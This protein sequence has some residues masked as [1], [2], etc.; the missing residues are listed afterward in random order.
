MRPPPRS[1]LFPYTTLFRSHVAALQNP[2]R[3]RRLQPAVHDHAQRLARRLDI[4]HR[5]PG[6]VGGDR[7]DPRQYGAG[8]SPPAMP[9][10]PR[11]RSRDPLGF[12]VGKRGAAIERGRH[13]E[14]HP[15]P[16]ARHAR[17]EADVQLAG[18]VLEQT[19]LERDA[20]ANE[21]FAA[22]RGDRIRVTHRR[23]D[24]PDFRLD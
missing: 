9:V 7:A 15:R 10:A 3:A 18:L 6:V 13:L 11:L 12:A 19:V 24:A 2:R 14:P 5:E 21:S 23:Y 20:G 8:A 1:T 22:V 17:D 4:A 16:A